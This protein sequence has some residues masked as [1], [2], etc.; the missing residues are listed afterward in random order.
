MG[1]F[2]VIFSSLLVHLS[3]R[4]PKILLKRQCRLDSQGEYVKE[5]AKLGSN[6]WYRMASML[7]LSA[8]SE[9][10]GSLAL[11]GFLI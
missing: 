5:S 10:R 6:A 8:R 7:D 3:Q 9:P 2:Q 1:S 11:T 4:C